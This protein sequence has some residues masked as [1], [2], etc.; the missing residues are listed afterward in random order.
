MTGVALHRWR[1]TT[2]SP[3]GRAPS[4]AIATAGGPW[5]TL[6]EPG[7][8][9]AFPDEATARGWDPATP[10]TPATP[11]AEQ[12]DGRPPYGTLTDPSRP[13]TLSRTPAAPVR[14]AP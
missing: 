8:D 1:A 3:D 5:L 6:H 10:A 13:P 4:G 2:R 9:R 14:P 7:T 12:L 11:A